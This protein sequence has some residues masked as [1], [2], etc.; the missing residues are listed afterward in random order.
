MSVT[1]DI[2]EP[3]SLDV[4]HAPRKV[5][6][7]SEQLHWYNLT[8]RPW[9]TPSLAKLLP[10]RQPGYWHYGSCCPW[11]QVRERRC[12]AGTE[13]KRGAERCCN[14]CVKAEGRGGSAWLTRCWQ[15]IDRATGRAGHGRSAPA[16]HEDSHNGRQG[17]PCCLHTPRKHSH[18]LMYARIHK[19]THT[20]TLWMLTLLGRQS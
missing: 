4:T 19:P 14:V 8:V 2:L 7:R 11:R 20:H 10:W 18:S 6:N 9:V 12:D 3:E 13:V 16:A 15:D 1:L 5:L 17:L